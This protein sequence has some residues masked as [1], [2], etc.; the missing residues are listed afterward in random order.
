[1]DSFNCSADMFKLLCSFHQVPPAFLNNIFSFGATL[2][3]LDY[4][5]AAFSNEDTILQ[6]ESNLL[7]VPSL[8][9][10]G[11]E[12]RHSYLLRSVEES[13][14][15]SGWGW[16]IRQV[17]I[18][19]SFDLVTGHT[20]WFT[21]KGNPLIKDRINEYVSKNSIFQ[22]GS[23][24]TLP[25]SF[26]ATL[27]IHSMIFDWCDESW[28]WF[29]ND[30]EKAARKIIDKAKT[31]TIND[32]PKLNQIPDGIKQNVFRRS[33]TM[34]S[35]SVSRSNTLVESIHQGVQGVRRFITWAKSRK[36]DSVDEKTAGGAT[37][38]KQSIPPSTSNPMTTGE[39]KLLER[40]AILDMFSF[41]E[42]Q[43][44]QEVAEKIQHGLLVIK[45]DLNVLGQI[46]NYYRRLSRAKN[47]PSLNVIQKE[48]Q[49]DFLLFDQKAEAI[50]MSLN[51]R[52]EQLQS[53]LQLVGDGRT[54]VS[55]PYKVYDFTFRPDKSS[56][57]ESCSIAVCKSAKFTPKARTNHRERWRQSPGKQS[58]RLFLCT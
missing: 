24:P 29:I 27:D 46:A 19:H 53:L 56:M 37:S 14:S 18:Y 42:M 26:A 39:E 5:L 38:P 11:R 54:L 13:D 50:K 8:G 36:E 48:C 35:K 25:E 55:R 12:I 34:N 1:M 58:R 10:S 51:I 33:S 2:H 9:R 21:V 20:T 47:I 31:I 28:R 30:V 40:L 22:R 49:N 44:L 3:P 7:P 57:M 23:T 43:R 6:R 45:L 52:K 16:G 4:G 15:V 32:D 41:E 17:A